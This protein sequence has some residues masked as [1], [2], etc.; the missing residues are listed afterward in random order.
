M[1]C[2]KM[3]CLSRRLRLASVLSQSA[4]EKWY[5]WESISTETPASAHEASTSPMSVP[6]AALRKTLYCG[7]GR[8][9]CHRRVPGTGLGDRRVPARMD[10]RAGAQPGAVPLAPSS[11]SR[12]ISAMDRAASGSPRRRPP[13]RRRPTGPPA[14]RRRRRA[15]VWRSGWP[16]PVDA[17]RPPG[18]VHPHEADDLPPGRLGNQD[19]DD[20]GARSPE[21][22]RPER[23]RPV[24]RLRWPGEEH[25][26]HQALLGWSAPGDRE[27]DAGQQLLPLP[28][29]PAPQVTVLRGTPHVSAADA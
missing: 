20:V 16:R 18:A 15:P 26:R 4:R 10:L 25:R 24:I 13:A 17:R 12:P 11:S 9:D 1:L 23:G 3:P 27:V 29:R 2:G 14:P 6:S 21:P 8:P 19:V 28:H 22:V 5:S 7:A